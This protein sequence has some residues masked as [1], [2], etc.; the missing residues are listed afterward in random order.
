MPPPPWPAHPPLSPVLM[1]DATITTSSC[2]GNLPGIPAPFASLAPHALQRPS[3]WGIQLNHLS[4]LVPTLHSPSSSPPNPS[5]RCLRQP[6]CLTG[7]T[8]DRAEGGQRLPWPQGQE[9][10]ETQGG[11][12]GTH[13]HGHFPLRLRILA[14]WNW[15]CDSGQDPDAVSSLHCV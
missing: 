13:D 11:K 14:S 12:V 5:P 9:V 1:K 4:I 6:S 3:P 8:G 15:L 10:A 7:H 2:P